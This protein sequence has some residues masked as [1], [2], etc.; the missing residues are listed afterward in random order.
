MG[1]HSAKVIGAS[2]GLGLVLA[3]AAASVASAGPGGIGGLSQRIENVHATAHG[4]AI[5]SVE[6]TCES[7]EMVTG[8]G[9]QVGS[10]GSADKVFINAPLN[11]KTWLVQIV[12]DG[13]ST[14]EVDVWAFAVCVSRG[15]S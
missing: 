14:H 12:V 4:G 6:A 8:G 11:D 5:T 2:V 15:G 7:D 1:K 13:P 9:Y 10:I 3:F